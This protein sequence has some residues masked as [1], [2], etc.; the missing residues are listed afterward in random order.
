MK[1]GVAC[2]LSRDT[3][4]TDIP[5]IAHVCVCAC[6][7]VSLCVYYLVGV[8]VGALGVGVGACVS[9]L[10]R[11]HACVSYGKYIYI[12]CDQTRIF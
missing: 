7:C 9:L 4:S 6:A 3:L 8:G 11:L 5:S 10:V 12:C 2:F 1:K